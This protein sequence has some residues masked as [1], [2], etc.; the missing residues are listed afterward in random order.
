MRWAA[1]FGCGG[2]L[3]TPWWR[4]DA[5]SPPPGA[6]G[7]TGKLVAEHLGRHYAGPDAPTKA[8]A[9]AA[10][11]GSDTAARFRCGAMCRSLL[12]TPAPRTQV[13][14]ALAG[15]D[16]AKLTA[17]REG[18]ARD[19]PAMADVPLLS[20]DPSDDAAMDKLIGSAR[21]VLTLAG[22]YARH[23]APVVAAAVRTK[24]HYCDIT[25][26]ESAAAGSTMHARVLTASARRFAQ[27][28]RSSCWRT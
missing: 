27:A 19:I 10:S 9:P 13:R 6:T 11:R 24:T 1:A 12:N 3:R 8:R 2:A 15:R 26:A 25:G 5:N 28:S 17:L 16:R 23:G 18:L 14:F 4:A 22:P 21:V 20:A 7:F